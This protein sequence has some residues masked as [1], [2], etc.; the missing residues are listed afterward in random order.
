MPAELQ[1]KVMTAR[2]VARYLKVYRST[3]YRLI[4]HYSLPGFKLG[5]DWRFKIESIERW[6]LDHPEILQSHQRSTGSGPMLPTDLI[7]R[8]YCEW[9]K[10]QV[11][12]LRNRRADA[13]DWDGLSMEIE[14]CR[15]REKKRRD[16]K[17][18]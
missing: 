17:C 13:L 2:E 4:K 6:C 7:R 5:S 10:E 14:A 18:P 9:A 12:A 15:Q 8:D 3:V 11:L 16:E 1:S